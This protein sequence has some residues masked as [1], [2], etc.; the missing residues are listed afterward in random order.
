M[1]THFNNRS[2]PPLTAEQLQSVGLDP[3]DLWWSPTFQTWV[4]AGPIVLQYPYTTTGDLICKLGLTPNP[5]A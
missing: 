3:D 5:Q 4:F 1:K 2:I